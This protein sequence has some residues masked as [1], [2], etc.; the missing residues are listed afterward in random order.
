MARPKQLSRTIPTDPEAGLYPAEAAVLMGC[1]VSKFWQ[2]V[3]LYG[4]PSFECGHEKRFVRCVVLYYRD[5]KLG[6]KPVRLKHEMELVKQPN[7]SSLSPEEYL[8]LAGL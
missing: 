2:Y 5:T 4:I 1:S 7:L 8:R 3:K 6:G